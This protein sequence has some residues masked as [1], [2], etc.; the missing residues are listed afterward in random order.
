MAKKKYEYKTTTIRLPDGRRKYI[1]AKTKKELEEKVKA[2]QRELSL[3]VD[4]SSDITFR[5]YADN[6]LTV[7]KAPYLSPNTL[8][9]CRARL[10][11]HVYPII[12]SMKVRDI[13]ASHILYVMRGVSYLCRGSQSQVL[14]ALRNIFNLAVDDNLILRS[15]VPL[16]LTAKG[17]QTKETEPLTPEQEAEILRVSEGHLLYP[18]VYIALH[19]GMRRGEITGLM[20]SDVDFDREVIHVRRHAVS[21]A[22]NG[23]AKLMDGA[24]TGAGVRD[25]PMPKQL[26]V[27]LRKRMS[28]SR[29]L[30]VVPNRKGQIYSASALTS[31]WSNMQKHLS[32]KVHPHQL[33]HTYITKLFEAGLDIKQIQY[34][35]G[36]ASEAMTLKVYTHYRKNARHSD[37]IRQIQAAF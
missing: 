23:K 11:N 4:I 5:E 34:V 33:R 8:I 12:G 26:I 2:A 7:R 27:Y 29:S 30:Y 17:G 36:H 14:G 6:W 24:K 22:V 20:W 19:T 35:A 37:T 31:I 25:I 10:E 9:A 1:R 16:T 15:P 21:D 18:F 13:R 32:F 3:G 28:E